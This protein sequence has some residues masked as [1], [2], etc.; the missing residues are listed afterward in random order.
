LSIVGFE[1]GGFGHLKLET[2]APTSLCFHHVIPDASMQPKRF[3]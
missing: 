3:V 1:T 2:L